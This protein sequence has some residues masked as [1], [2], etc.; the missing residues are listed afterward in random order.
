M[1]NKLLDFSAAKKSTFSMK[2]KE[3]EATILLYAA[4]GQSMWEDSVSAKDFS[5]ELKKLPDSIKT[6]NVR[7]NSVGGSV[8]CGVSIYERL[9]THS[10]KIVVYVDGIAASIA[11]IIAMAGDE[12]IIGEGAF[13]MVHA[14][15]S[16][17]YG[18][19]R[20]MEDMIEVLDRIEN[21]MIG[22]YAR[23]T[24]LSVAEISKMLKKDTWI[25]AE[26][27]VEMGF[28]TR[29]SDTDEA[30][31]RVAASMLTKAD[32]IKS[33]PGLPTEA[34]MARQK[35]NEFKNDVK[36]FLARK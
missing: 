29:I 32:W 3:T 16:G 14:P 18:N 10:A 1:P 34:A 15:M 11:S 28:A 19:A 22:I 9:K 35:V 17:V 25:N 24:G 33:N 7:I 31:V 8:F 6:I 12:I 13:F 21:Q 20:E 2:V 27:A 23:K 26:E 5:D 36:K 4:I 30:Q